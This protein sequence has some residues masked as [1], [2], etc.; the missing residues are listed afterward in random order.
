MPPE[1]SVLA[2]ASRSLYT[3]VNDLELAD[4]VHAA[5]S[6]SNNTC[7]LYART[8]CRSDG[9]IHEVIRITI[10]A[11]YQLLRLTEIAQHCKRIKVSWSIVVLCKLQYQLWPTAASTILA[12]TILISSQHCA[13]GSARSGITLLC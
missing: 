4:S 3:A 1:K 8:H 6:V 12:S 10:C 2:T 11:P 13:A 9:A 5:G 7:T